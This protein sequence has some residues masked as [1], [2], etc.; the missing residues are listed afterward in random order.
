MEFLKRLFGG[1]GVPSGTG[2]EQFAMYFYVRPKRS[3]EI[4]RVRIDMRNDLSQA[5]AGGYFVRKVVRATRAPFPAEL[6][7]NFD[8]RRRVSGVEVENGEVVDESIYQ[9]WLASQGENA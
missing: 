1:G 7:V 3:E 6:L 5:D 8:D 4:M 2:N 9:E